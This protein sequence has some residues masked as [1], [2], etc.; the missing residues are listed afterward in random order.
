MD[1][2]DRQRHRVYAWEEQFIA[3]RD[4]SLIEPAQ[5]QGM[6]DAIWAETGLRFPPKVER[7]P[8]QARSTMA[9]ASRLSI[10]LAD[11]SPSWCLLH[12]LAHAM[13]STHD[14]H[15]DGHG[16]TFM[17]LYAQLLIRYLRVPIDTLLQSIEVAR[18]EADMQ[19]KPVFIDDQP[20]R[21]ARTRPSASAVPGNGGINDA[22]GL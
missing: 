6:I 19:A 14:G 22:D 17:G 7:L 12:E 3:P 5:A 13:S 8:R 9:D 21:R 15:S 4:P 1:D 10:R 2:R 18:I 11:S 20:M 16:P